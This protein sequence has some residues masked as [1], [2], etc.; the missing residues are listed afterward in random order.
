VPDPKEIKEMLFKLKKTYLDKG[1]SRE[2][3]LAEKAELE[4][5]LKDLGEAR[6]PGF[7]TPPAG[8]QVTI[9]GQVGATQ[10][11]AKVEAT[12]SGEA[13][14]TKPPT[15]EKGG[16]EL[17]PGSTFS[18]RYRI[19]AKLGAGGMGVT[20]KAHDTR[21]D[22]QVCLKVIR[23]ELAADPGIVK[24]FLNE[25][26]VGMKLL[27][28]N[29]VRVHDVGEFENRLFL[30]M[31]YVQGT[32][33]RQW[34]MAN[35]S[36][37]R[38]IPVDQAL[39]VARQILIPLCEAH[40]KRV[41]HRDLKPENVILV[42]NPG[43]QG[44]RAEV[45]DFG[46]A[47]VLEGPLLTF[48]GSRMGTTGYMAPEQQTRAETADPSADVYAMGV[49]L[50]EM[51]VG[52]LPV[53]VVERPHEAREDCPRWLSDAVMKA[54]ATS[55]ARRFAAA[56]EFLLVLD[57]QRTET[58]SKMEGAEESRALEE[59]KR[60]KEK[61]VL[62]DREYSQ[63]RQPQELNRDKLGGIGPNRMA[64]TE[65]AFNRALG[66]ISRASMTREPS[67]ASDRLHK[68]SADQAFDQALGAIPGASGAQSPKTATERQR[69]PSAGDNEHDRDRSW[70]YRVQN[71]LQ[72][73]E[74]DEAIKSCDEALNIDP[75]NAQMWANKGDALFGSDRHEEA[76]R[77]YERALE[78][79][80]QNA[81]I[82][83]KK[84]DVSASHNRMEEA[85]QC[86][87]KALE[88]NPNDAE[89]WKIKGGALC[90]IDRE[91][92]AIECFNKALEINPHDD[93][94]WTGKGH[95]LNDL[96]R[97]EEAI[98]C[99]DKTLAID[100]RD[101][102]TWREKGDALLNSGR[103]EEAIQCYEKALKIDPEDDWAWTQKGDA[104]R[105][106]DRHKEAIRCFDKALEIT[107]QHAIAL[108]L[109][110]TSLI[111]IGRRKEGEQCKR[112]AK[113]ID[114]EVEQCQ[115]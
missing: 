91:E 37:G 69:Q 65:E 101:S 32:P 20:Y 26:K 110:G 35:T 4:A 102:C 63:G 29:F 81:L 57:V 73:H 40:K 94:A 44:F 25:A 62:V 38:S 111:L 108:F 60:G 113:E 99:Y 75:L 50:Y 67:Q 41:I 103:R 66:A 39:E 1:I 82:W 8:G 36:K 72:Q 17:E 47:K 55:P 23:P 104:L 61:A 52:V 105:G 11:P 114:P 76:I 92:E 10:T 74:Y 12:I 86:C 45:L 18:G 106:L 100:P 53:G 9:S 54:L 84:G 5:M 2:E 3:Y 77:C 56:R 112:L 87:D 48:E 68:L 88:I 83:A 90:S 43:E 27:H 6:P 107:P 85:I 19:E 30:S 98:Q 71:L 13:G 22:E 33:M 51:L 7:T 34:L 115:S 59:R 70:A 31:E 64:T 95:A 109:K 14:R 49:M 16:G 46:I 24:R 80:P 78:I 96:D 42:G 93:D 79:D 89:A 28:E 97:Y 58:K 15:Q 21:L